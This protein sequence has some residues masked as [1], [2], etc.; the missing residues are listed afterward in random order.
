MYIPYTLVKNFTDETLQ[1]ELQLNGGRKMMGEIKPNSM[2][3]FVDARVGDTLLLFND[4]FHGKEVLN[5]AMNPKYY[6]TH[7]KDK[8]QNMKDNRDYHPIVILKKPSVRSKVPQQPQQISIASTTNETFNWK[9]F[10]AFLLMLVVLVGS[11]AAI[12]YYT[13]KKKYG[14]SSI[15][16]PI[17]QIEST[18]I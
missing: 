7:K 6:I 2:V 8:I 18:M 1:Y 13:S 14:G 17:E 11:L 3:E 9:L 16:N 12:I 4:E 5:Y 15:S 10:F